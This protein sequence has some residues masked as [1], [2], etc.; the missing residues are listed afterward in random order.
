[1]HAFEDFEIS[2]H[3]LILL[4]FI[5]ICVLDFRDSKAVNDNVCANDQIH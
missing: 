1:M 5:L 2:F 3:L 4:F